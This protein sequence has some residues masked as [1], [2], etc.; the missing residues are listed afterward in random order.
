MVRTRRRPAPSDDHRHHARRRL[1]DRERKADQDAQEFPLLR[2]DDRRAQRRRVLEHPGVDR[3]GF[4]I[5]ATPSCC[6]TR[7][8]PTTTSPPRRRSHETRRSFFLESLAGAAVTLGS[9]RVAHRPQRRTLRAARSP[10]AAPTAAANCAGRATPPPTSANVQQHGG[11]TAAED[12]TADAT[13]CSMRAFSGVEVG[14]GMMRLP[15]RTTAEI[16]CRFA[17]LAIGL[18]DEQHEVGV[19]AGGRRCPSCGSRPRN[20]GAV[21]RWSSAGSSSGVSPLSASRSNS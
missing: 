14:S 21:A 19:F 15:A 13:R 9:L 16:S 20:V 18:A 8:S 11:P 4:A 12:G 6:P 17:A 2:L 10:A 1:P 3:A 7:R 5:P